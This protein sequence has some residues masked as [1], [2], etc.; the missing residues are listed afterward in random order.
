MLPERRA[1]WQHHSGDVRFRQ[2][3]QHHALR[4]QL[5][6]CRALRQQ[7]VRRRALPLHDSD[8]RHAVRATCALAASQ[9]R[10]ALWQ[11]LQRRRA[12]SVASQR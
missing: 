12:L 9:R 8:M 3:H 2:Q 1:L 7:N 10:R 6:R 5:R 4:H 11:Q